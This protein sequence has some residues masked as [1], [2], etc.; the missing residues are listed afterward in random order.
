MKK[1][2][3]V[4]AF[5]FDSVIASYRRPFEQD[6]LGFPEIEVT[7]T[8]NYYYKQGFYILIYTGRNKTLKIKK[9]LKMYDVKYHG[10]NTNPNKYFNVSKSYKPYFNVLIDDK[11][12]NYHYKY[13]TK[14]SKELIE[15][16]DKVFRWSQE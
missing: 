15:E 16:I 9:W 7:E 1:Y 3:G 2:K 12:V 11:T 10:I 5:D 14:T 13:N 6:V 8:M 4:I